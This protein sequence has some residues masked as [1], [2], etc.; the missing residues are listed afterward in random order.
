MSSHM[1]GNNQYSILLRAVEKS[2][3]KLDL[4]PSNI[5]KPTRV[6]LFTFDNRDL[7][8]LKINNRIYTCMFLAD[9][10]DC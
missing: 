4:V 6:E 8:L 10:H 1:N 3:K 2:A 9:P 5:V 7:T